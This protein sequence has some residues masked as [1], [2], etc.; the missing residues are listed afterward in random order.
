MDP[1]PRAQWAGGL[2]SDGITVR[3]KRLATP[4]PSDLWWGPGPTPPHATHTDYS[5]RQITTMLPFV[6]AGDCPTRPWDCELP[7]PKEADQLFWRHQV[8]V[9]EAREIVDWLAGRR[10]LS[11]AERMALPVAFEEMLQRYHILLSQ[12][13]SW[14]D[15]GESRAV[16]SHARLDGG[17]KSSILA[18]RFSRIHVGGDST[19]LAG[20]YTRVVAGPRSIVTVGGGSLV[21]AGDDCR[22]ELGHSSYAHCGAGTR[23]RVSGHCSVI[24][25]VGERE[26]LACSSGRLSPSPF[27]LGNESDD[28]Y[29]LPPRDPPSGVLRMGSATYLLTTSG[30][31]AA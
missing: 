10:T 8:P 6:R 27:P 23:V 22:L 11:Y 9:A 13:E 25:V 1:L 18:R 2:P 31:V 17:P 30:W 15:P 12:A 5:G 21:A 28:V 24:G 19:V 4:P 3:G 20:D 7:T 16:S 29:A 26:F 14:V